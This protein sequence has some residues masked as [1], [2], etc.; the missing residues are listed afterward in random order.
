MC[1]P[2]NHK[3]KTHRKIGIGFDLVLP[4][5]NVRLTT[6]TTVTGLSCLPYSQ[7]TNPFFKMSQ[8]PND[9]HII[10]GKQ[11]SP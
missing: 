11:S 8:K 3:F 10:K 2:L 7:H 4:K 5:L 1:K 6:P 9:N